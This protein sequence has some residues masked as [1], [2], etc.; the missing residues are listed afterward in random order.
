MAA[1][2]AALS[3]RGPR[4]LLSA[5]VIAAAALA[6][7]ALALWS[8]SPYARYLQHSA[9]SDAAWF[10][11]LC[12]TLPS[13]SWALPT[14][15]HLLAW[16]LMIT[17]MMLPTTLPL[18]SSFRRATLARRDA[19]ALHGLV[20][21]GYVLAWML[22]G[23]IAHGLDIAV[24]RALSSSGWLL[25]HA[26]VIGAAVLALA[27]GFQF[28]RLKYRCLERCRAP[29]G[30]LNARWRG[31]HPKRESLRIGFDHGMFCVGC[32]WALMLLMFVLGM[33]N[34][35]WMLAI[36]VVM[37]IEKNIAWGRQLSRVLGGA[38]IAAAAVSIATHA[39]SR[40]TGM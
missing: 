6:W 38:L 22:F 28:T 27:G 13:V 40:G 37:A 34:L 25:V 24:H 11:D 2:A 3:A 18:L 16:L 32:C 26:W 8:A 9:W 1:H 39:F 30:F 12:T 7:A 29:F 36:G 35:A 4:A 17:G 10:A 19:A 5:A 15:M 33:G 21:A 31:L 14:T 23:V 20:I